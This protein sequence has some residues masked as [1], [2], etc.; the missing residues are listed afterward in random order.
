MK[1]V[2]QVLLAKIDEILQNLYR[3]KTIYIMKF[4]AHYISSVFYVC[5]CFMDIW[6]EIVKKQKCDQI[7]TMFRLH[8]SPHTSR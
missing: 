1:E 8:H 6:E 3:I 2:L 4:K 5:V 7:K